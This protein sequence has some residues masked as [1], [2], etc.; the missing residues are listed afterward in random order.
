MG[1]EI[2]SL[3]NQTDTHRSR[4]GRK[5]EFHSFQGF[6]GTVDDAC[7]LPSPDDSLVVV[8]EASG[9]Q[10]LSLLILSENFE[11]NDGSQASLSL[12]A[13]IC[14][15]RPLTVIDRRSSNIGQ[16]R[17][18]VSS[19]AT[20]PKTENYLSF[21]S[22]GYDHVVQLWS[23][24][25]SFSSPPTSKV[26]R[27]HHSSVIHSMLVVEDGT[28]KLISAGADCCVNVYN[29][30]AERTDYTIRTSNS[31]YQVHKTDRPECLLLEAGFHRYC[32]KCH[33]FLMTPKVAHRDSQ[34]ELYD[35]R[36]FARRPVRRFGYVSP[37]VQGR[38]SR[39]DVRVNGAVSFIS[40]SRDGT[41]R[42]WDLRNVSRCMQEASCS[43]TS[44]TG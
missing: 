33:L 43:P 24:D 29:L 27:I 39:G 21:T 3:M 19:V 8:A 12:K 42:L 11:S 40:G 28:P 30:G 6:K 32:K 20:I 9:E 31:V 35:Y 36:T 22:A 17:Q 34:Y 41:L 5:K 23:L 38:Y 7:T 25:T 14:N 44:M 26:L 2:T 18:G 37:W 10:P 4:F 16:L 13:G 1:P 15:K